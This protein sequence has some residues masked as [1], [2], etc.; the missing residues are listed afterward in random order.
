MAGRAPSGAQADGSLDIL[1]LAAMRG[2]VATA[3]E[4]Q[5]GTVR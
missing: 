1:G 4:R 5:V 2:C 3:I